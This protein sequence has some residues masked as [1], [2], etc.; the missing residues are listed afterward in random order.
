MRVTLIMW[1]SDNSADI[2][3]QILKHNTY[4]NDKQIKIDINKD[5]ITIQS[6]LYLNSNK[7]IELIEYYKQLSMH[8]KN[9]MGVDIK[10]YDDLDWSI[11]LFDAGQEIISQHTPMLDNIREIFVKYK[12]LRM[13]LPR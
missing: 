6:L 1:D 12:D 5:I 3:K 2:I 9:N 8:Y 7:I 11:I 4:S 13:S 10:D